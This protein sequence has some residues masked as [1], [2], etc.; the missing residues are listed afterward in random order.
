MKALSGV[1]A[2]VI[3]VGTHVDDPL[4]TQTFVD[5]VFQRLLQRLGPSY[6]QNIQTCV[7]VSC[8]TGENVEELR[9]LLAGVVAAHAPDAVQSL[10]K[11][12]SPPRLRTTDSTASSTPTQSTTA[13]TIDDTARAEQRATYR[14]LY[15]MLGDRL[16]A[17]IAHAPAPV[18]TWSQLQSL[19]EPLRL[20]NKRLLSAITHLHCCG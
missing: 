9:K 4:C 2:P 12:H 11:H 7:P 8:S 14:A 5:G 15:H 17:S 1:R 6:Q 20:N 19:A 10:N 16:D 13:T 3:I 18:I